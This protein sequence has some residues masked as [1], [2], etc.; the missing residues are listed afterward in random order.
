MTWTSEKKTR[1][2]VDEL[3]VTI[4]GKDA[5][6]LD[7][8]ISLKMVDGNYHLG[9]HIADVSYYVEEDTLLD[10]EA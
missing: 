4:D 3:I 9:V 2:T 6:D 1:E 7:D 8:A 10:K 5:K